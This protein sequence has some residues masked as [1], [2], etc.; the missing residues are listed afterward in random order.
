ML[1]SHRKLKIFPY[2]YFRNHVD[3]LLHLLTSLILQL[4]VS[5]VLSELLGDFDIFLDFS[6]NQLFSSVNLDEKDY[7]ETALVERSVS[8]IP[9]DFLTNPRHYSHHKGQG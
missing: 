8:R 2:I 5:W 1:Y 4:F 9:T 6:V 3:M 7:V